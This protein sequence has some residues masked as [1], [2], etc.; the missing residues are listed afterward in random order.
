MN[1]LKNPFGSVYTFS[2]LLGIQDIGKSF[3][4]SH[5]S[6]IIEHFVNSV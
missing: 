1:V 4:R 2:L 5:N 3:V 6:V